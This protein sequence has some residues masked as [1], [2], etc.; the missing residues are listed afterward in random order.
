MKKIINIILAVCIVG[1]VYIVTCSIMGPIKFDQEKSKRDKA[2]INR[3]IDI[4]SAQVEFHAQ[5]NGHYTASFDTL[6]SFVKTARLPL[7]NKIGELSDNQLDDEWTTPKVMKLYYE[8]KTAKTKKER[9]AKWKEAEKAG[10]VKILDNGEIEYYFN[11]DT[12]WVN[13]LDS[14]Y[15]KG[16]NPDSLR[17]VPFGNGAQ[18]EMAVGMDTTK[19]GSFMYLFEAKVPYATYL[20]GLD[21]QE[22][23]NIINECEQLDRYP[24]MK[25][26]DAESGNNN[27]G[28]WE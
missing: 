24:G 23:Y 27:A 2:V 9:D 4:R 1:L 22:V 14:I 28:N 7:I 5:N 8:A 15:P 25:V 13:L 26:G 21:K 12:T 10:F 16:F 17:Y 18:F 19:S 20:E 11:R 3:L 6:I